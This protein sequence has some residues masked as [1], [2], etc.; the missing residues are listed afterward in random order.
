[1]KDYKLD[2]V[3]FSLKDLHMLE[4]KQLN[5]VNIMK[6]HLVSNE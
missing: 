2:A 1:M 6:L 3:E 5:S 4:H